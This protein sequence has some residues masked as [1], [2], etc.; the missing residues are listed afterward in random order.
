M[1][2]THKSPVSAAAPS[3]SHTGLVEADVKVRVSSPEGTLPSLELLNSH[4][5]VEVPLG[6][7]LDHVSDVIRFTSLLEHQ[8]HDGE[9]KHWQC[10][11]I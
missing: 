3:H 1:G 8:D 5:Q 4:H 10:F 2:K 6:V 9:I 11:Q 7:L